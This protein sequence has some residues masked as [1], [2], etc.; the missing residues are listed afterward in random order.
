MN[1]LSPTMAD[2][3]NR[4]LSK[5]QAET[6]AAGMYDLGDKSKENLIFVLSGSAESHA[7]MKRYFKLDSV[8]QLIVNIILTQEPLD[9]IETHFS[10]LT[11]CF[12]EVHKA[13]GKIEYIHY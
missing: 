9:E 13:I 5:S 10:Y 2:F 6:I 1:L 11:K 7:R 12:S 3:D 4:K 8:T